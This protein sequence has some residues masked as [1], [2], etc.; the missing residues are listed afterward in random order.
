MGRVKSLARTIYAKNQFGAPLEIVVEEKILVQQ[1]NTK[2]PT[3]CL[4]VQG[5]SKTHVIHRLVLTAFVGPKP[6]GMLCR[7]FPDRNPLNNRLDNLSWGTPK[8]NAADRAVHGTTNRGHKHSAATK[9]RM[10]K[11]NRELWAARH[12][13]GY[14]NSRSRIIEH[15]G[16]SLTITEWSRR[17]GLEVHVIKNRIQSGWPTKDA[18]FTPVHKQY[19]SKSLYAKMQSP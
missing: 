19:S 16:M 14:R 15:D 8:Q 12:S 9:R 5:K 7:H 11:I 10:S 1:T 2:Y 3:V 17:V 6:D 18:L 13:S 4:S